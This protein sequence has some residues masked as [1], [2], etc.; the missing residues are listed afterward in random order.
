MGQKEAANGQSE[1]DIGVMFLPMGV[2]FLSMGVVFLSIGV[3]FLSIS[4]RFLSWGGVLFVSTENYFKKNKKQGSKKKV[5]V[6]KIF[7]LRSFY[8]NIMIRCLVLQTVH[9]HQK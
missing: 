6:S 4:V 3:I 7:I 9:S 5:K 2:V 8:T 1:E